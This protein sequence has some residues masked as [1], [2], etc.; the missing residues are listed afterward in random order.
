MSYKYAKEISLH[1]APTVLFGGTREGNWHIEI[2]PQ[3]NV[4]NRPT[5]RS[6]D[7]NRNIFL[8]WYFLPNWQYEHITITRFLSLLCPL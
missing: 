7:R 8:T 3:T 5:T 4:T 2:F 1:Q 6:K